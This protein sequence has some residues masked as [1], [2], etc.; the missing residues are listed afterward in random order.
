M[1]QGTQGSI[2]SDNNMPVTGSERL[3]DDGHNLRGYKTT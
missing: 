2:S 3:T 1:Q